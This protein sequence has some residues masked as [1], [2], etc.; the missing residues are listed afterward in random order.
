MK[1]RRISKACRVLSFV[2]VMPI[3]LASCGGD[4]TGPL[5]GTGNPPLPNGDFV[6]VSVDGG[7]QTMYIESSGLPSIDCDP[8]VDWAFTQVIGWADFTNGGGPNGYD[9]FLD[10][11]FPAADTVGT[12]TVQG[13]N[14]QAIFYSGQYFTASPI[15]PASS[16]TVQIT[17]SDSRIEGTFTLTAVDTLGTNP[18][19]FAGNFGIDS[20]ISLSC[21]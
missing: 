7:A 14:M 1:T 9:V 6:S 17:R 4:D 18:V 5:T 19:N 13:D 20:G 10:L 2:I 21:P 11:L 12:Y 16:G 3:V 15:L 8:R